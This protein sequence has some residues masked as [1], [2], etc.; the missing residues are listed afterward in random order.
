MQSPTFRLN[1]YPVI[2]TTVLFIAGIMVQYYF[3]LDLLTLLCLPVIFLTLSFIPA[4]LIKNE[5]IKSVLSQLIIIPVILFGSLTLYVHNLEE[6]QPPFDQHRVK[7]IKLSGEVVSIDLIN[8]N[9]FRFIL[10]T[11]SILSADTVIRNEYTFQLTVKEKSRKK[12]LALYNSISPGNFFYVEGDYRKGKE[13][14]NPGEFDYNKYLQQR[15]ISATVVVD[16]VNKIKILDRK[17]SLFKSFIF[18]IRKYIAENIEK[19]HGNNTAG[20]LKGLLL[21]DRSD[22]S[23]ETKNM[24]INSGVIHVLAVSGLHVGFIAVIFLFLFG[25]FNVKLKIF[26]TSIGLLFFLLLTGSPPSVFRATIM[27]LTLLFALLTNRDTNGI[28]SLFLAAFIIL[29]LNPNDLFHPGF[30]LSFA[31]VLSILLVNPFFS[32]VIEERVKSNSIKNILLFIAVSLSAQLGTLPLTIIYF[33]KVS[34]IALIANLFVIPVIAVIVSNGIFTVILALISFTAASIF[35]Y[36]SD[37]LTNILFCFVNFAGGLSFSHLRVTQFTVIELLIYYFFF[38]FLL[39]YLNKFSKKVSKVLLFCF[40]IANCILFLSLN[41]S[42]LLPDGKLSVLMIDVG[43]GDATLVKFPDGTTYLIDAGDVMFSYDS[44]ERVIIPL[45]NYLNIEQVDAGLVS[46]M[47]TDHYGGFVSLVEKGRVKKI[48]KPSLDSNLVR[49]VKFEKFLKQ[50][51]IETSYFS[52]TIDSIGNTRIYY[53]NDLSKNEFQ[54]WRVNDK[55]G[56]FLI[57]HG[58]NEFLFTGDIEKKM[59]NYLISKFNQFL[60]ADILKVPH[61]GSNSSTSNFLLKFVKPKMSLISAGIQN[62]F[63]HPSGQV[64]ERIKNSGSEVFRTDIEGAIL[65]ISDGKNVAKMNWRN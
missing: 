18:E 6:I 3:Q 62:R 65:M 20:L 45:L 59:E 57:V 16:D 43:Q 44:G 48:L 15:G 30:Q 53:L 32:Q 56:C 38:L 8:E 23:E 7:N 27:A 34:V 14:R 52:E 26:L 10:K 4:L 37:A 55:S 13:A 60:L 54:K 31:A 19:L 35:A 41:D 36:A 49:D 1:N 42:K 12:L 63:K 21:A 22:I 40:V 29:L 24:F 39:Y 17:K 25:R 50:K 58:E 33:G 61:H 5:R 64:L 9:G 2:K 11:H 46:H 51:G 28:N 47:D